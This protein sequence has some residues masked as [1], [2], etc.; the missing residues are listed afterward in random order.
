MSALVY[1]ENSKLSQFEKYSYASSSKF[2]ISK[3]LESKHASFNVFLKNIT[4]YY[5]GVKKTGKCIKNK[6]GTK[7][8]YFKAASISSTMKRIAIAAL[9][10]V[11]NPAG[12]NF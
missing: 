11:I 5:V 12:I 9:S 4:F 6:T 1:I 3:F 8:H 10:N 7:F 2:K